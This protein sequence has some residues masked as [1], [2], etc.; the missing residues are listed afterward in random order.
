MAFC[1]VMAA[2]RVA[3][4]V[5][6]HRV[7][8][9]PLMIGA[10]SLAA[11]LY[12]VASFAPWRPVALVACIAMGL[13]ISCL[14]PSMLAAAADRFP[15]GGASMFALLAALGNGGG[16]V[17]PWLVGAVAAGTSMSWGMA[18]GTVPALLLVG[19]LVWMGRRDSTPTSPAAPR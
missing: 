10:C 6:G 13:A 14:W 4:G 17:M 5:V 15:T 3:A 2:G 1:V 16:I 9:V 7:R 12:L 11:C 18:T 8:A 19:L